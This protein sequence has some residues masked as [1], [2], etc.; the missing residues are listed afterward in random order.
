MNIFLSRR[1]PLFH[2][3]ARAYKGLKNTNPQE[4]RLPRDARRVH[5]AKMMTDRHGCKHADV[6]VVRQ[7]PVREGNVALEQRTRTTPPLRRTQ[8]Q[9]MLFLRG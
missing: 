4:D 6:G 1:S 7:N 3:K 9:R 8:P 2:R 5:K